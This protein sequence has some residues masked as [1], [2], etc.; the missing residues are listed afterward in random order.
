MT[1]LS[2]GDCVG[3]CIGDCSGD[4]IGDCIIK[5]EKESDIWE[6]KIKE[7]DKDEEERRKDG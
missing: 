3:D 6:K 1:K 7:K 2:F 4:C 5:K